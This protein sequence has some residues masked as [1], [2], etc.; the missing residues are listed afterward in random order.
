[1]GAGI[2]AFSSP[3]RVVSAPMTG[4][5]GIVSRPRPRAGGAF[6]VVT[7]TG[8]RRSYLEAVAEPSAVPYARRHTRQTLATWNLAAIT[9]DAE[10]I[11]SEM[12][13]NALTAT[14]A[15][16]AAAPVVLYLA[17]DPGRLTVLVWDAC[18]DLPA[19]R[20]HHD[21]AEGGRGLEIVEALSHAWGT[22]ALDRGKVTWAR[23]ALSTPSGPSDD[24]ETGTAPPVTE[25]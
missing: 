15:M 18:P 10:L 13:T 4:A 20:A 24:P 21:E 23:L 5:P 12:V 22:S 25:T 9:D 16:Q 14:R 7:G 6:H 19:P 1:M 8:N 3:G 17:A 2:Y 11:V